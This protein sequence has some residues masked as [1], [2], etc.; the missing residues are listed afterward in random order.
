V[1]S[2]L[3]RTG[4]GP[5]QRDGSQRAQALQDALRERKEPAAV[6]GLPESEALER[7]ALSEK[8]LRP[9]ELPV[10]QQVH[11]WAELATEWWPLVWVAN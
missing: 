1:L 4:L 10:L 7:W 8:G 11:L 6:P 2:V 3:A 9:Q 5:P